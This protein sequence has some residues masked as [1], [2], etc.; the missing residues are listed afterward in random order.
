MK[1]NKLT[2]TINNEDYYE[3]TD[4]QMQQVMDFIDKEFGNTQRKEEAWIVH[5]LTSK[6][7]H[8]DVVVTGNDDY[9]H[10][11]TCG[12]GARNMDCA[13]IEFQRILG[14]QEYYFLVSPD[15]ELSL[16]DKGLLCNELSSITKYPF[17]NNTFL[18]PGHTINASKKFKERFGYDFFVF[19]APVKELDVE[20]LGNVHF[21]PLIPI[22]EEEREWMGENNSFDWI[23]ALPNLDDAMCIDNQREVFIPNEQETESIDS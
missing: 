23:L 3:Y 6:Y 11:V 18:G 20:G 13:P 22:Y 8:T 2:K 17:R 1:E 9:Q 12:M 5:E 19:F 7:L 4:T 21:I 14:R 15:C 16:E 10:F